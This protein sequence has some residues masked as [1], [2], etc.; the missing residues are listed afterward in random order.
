MLPRQNPLTLPPPLPHEPPHPPGNLINPTTRNQNPR[1]GINQPNHQA[2]EPRPLLADQ[3]QDR[4][5]VV[6]E[7]DARNQIGTLGDRAGL[8][9]G[10]V[11]VCE[12][13]VAGVAG[14]R[15][16][17]V[18]GV[19]VEG[20]AAFCVESWYDREEVLEFVVVAW[21]FGDGF[22]ERVEE[23]GVVWAEGEFGDHV[24][25]VERCIAI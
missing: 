25:E 1:N 20:G 4:L 17:G 18:E 5:N 2:Q 13:G 12:D 6:L 16:G 11:L 3:Q 24:G 15:G 14:V 10:R 19:G 21:C 7:E 8:A 9:G 23:A 22:V